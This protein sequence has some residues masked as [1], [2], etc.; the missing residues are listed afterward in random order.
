MIRE[1]LV[2]PTQNNPH[3][4]DRTD[5]ISFWEKYRLWDAHLGVTRCEL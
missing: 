3:T 1:Q 2:P 4:T 5:P